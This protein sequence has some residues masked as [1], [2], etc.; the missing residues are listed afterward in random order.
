MELKLLTGILEQS[1][2]LGMRSLKI[3]GGEPLLYDSFMGLL[4]FLKKKGWGLFLYMETNGTMIDKKMAQALKQAGM[5]F[6]SV[7]ID[8]DNPDTHDKMRGIKGTFEKAIKAVESMVGQ[9]MPVQIIASVYRR[10][11]GEL[12]NIAKIAEGLKAESVKANIIT[13]MGRANFMDGNKELL[14]IEEM[15]ELNK[16]I[17]GEYRKRFKLRFCSSL[18]VAFRSFKRMLEEKTGF[19][20]VK[21]LLGILATGKVSICGIGEEIAELI[22]GDARKD[23]IKD[24]WQKN[25][26]LWRIRN[27]IPSKLEG[28]CKACLFKNYCLGHCIAKNYY[29]TGKFTSPF[30]ICQEAFEKQ[31]FPRGRFFAPRDGSSLP[32]RLF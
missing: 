22:L 17:E 7:S 3:T 16:K 19:C 28:I 12:E 15:L 5:K 32:N 10:N 8:G 4:E 25:P 14:S 11:L 29:S 6:V 2:N 13:S 26:V 24:I 18:P 27:D 30:W 31:L 1:R 23:S 9:G 20:R 21:G